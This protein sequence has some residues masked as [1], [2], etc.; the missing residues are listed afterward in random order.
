VLRHFDAGGAGRLEELEPTI[1]DLVRA[2]AL[3][4]R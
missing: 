1:D 3:G 4:Q 2:V